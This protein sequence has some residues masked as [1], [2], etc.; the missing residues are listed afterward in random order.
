[1]HALLDEVRSMIHVARSGGR[2]L[3]AFFFMMA[4]VG[5]TP[6]AGWSLPAVQQVNTD[7]GQLELNERTEVR[8][9][10][11]ISDQPEIFSGSFNLER[12]H[13]DGTVQRLGQLKDDGSKGDALAGDGNFTL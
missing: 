11:F 10:A 7:P 13:A 5:L 4:V 8:I 1:M 3:C 6:G 9:T 12:L 2:G